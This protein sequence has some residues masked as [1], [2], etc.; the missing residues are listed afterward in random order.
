MR[1]VDHDQ[2]LGPRKTQGEVAGEIGDEGV[3]VFYLR[4][5]M[6]LAYDIHLYSIVSRPTITFVFTSA[7]TTDSLPILSLPDVVD[8]RCAKT[9]P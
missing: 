5:Q 8:S 7:I 4:K 3:F 2:G 6:T 9:S 1:D